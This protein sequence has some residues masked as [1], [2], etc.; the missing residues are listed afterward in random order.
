MLRLYV[1][2]CGALAALSLLPWG[3]VAL[4]RPDAILAPTRPGESATGVMLA[5]AIVWLYPVFVGLFGLR[6]WQL[7]RS[8][9][10]GAAAGP[11]TLIGLPALALVLI[12][13]AARAG[14]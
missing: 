3:L 12:Y 5:L 10:Y 14:M 9:N 2:A 13:L 4:L 8:G 6:S 11:T 1:M 7:C